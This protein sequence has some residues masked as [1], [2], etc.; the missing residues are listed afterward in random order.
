[1]ESASLRAALERMHETLE[2]TDQIG[3]EERDVLIE[4][5]A[6]IHRLLKSETSDAMGLHDRAQSIALRFE[7]EYPR[8]AQIVEELAATLG[9]MGI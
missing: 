6:D 1:M 5:D 7:A 3:A 8:L 2:E 9:R 4:L